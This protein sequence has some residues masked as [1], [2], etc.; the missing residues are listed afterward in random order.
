MGLQ[1]LA[2]GCCCSGSPVG[3]VSRGQV[4]EGVGVRRRQEGSDSGREFMSCLEAWGRSSV[5]PWTG[6]APSSTW[7]IRV[8]LEDRSGLGQLYACVWGQAS[9]CVSP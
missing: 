5:R 3:G 8:W 1:D 4:A 7:S 9:K 6:A 2:E